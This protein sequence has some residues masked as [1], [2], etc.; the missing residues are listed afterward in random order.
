MLGICLQIVSDNCGSITACANSLDGTVGAYRFAL[1]GMRCISTMSSSQFSSGLK[2]L[3]L[4]DIREYS[5]LRVT[6]LEILL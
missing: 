5:R 2:M 4:Y 3:L 6:L 1:G